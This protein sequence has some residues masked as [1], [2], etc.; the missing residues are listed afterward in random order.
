[1]LDRL[2]GVFPPIPTTFDPATGEVDE[3]AVAANVRRW[4]K[5]GLAGVLALGSNGEAGSLDE[6]EG[7]RLV[8]AAREEVPR[9]R[10]MLVGT[11]KEST[12]ATIRATARAAALGADAVLVRTPSYFKAQMT[13]EALLAHFRA[14]A[15]ASPFPFLLYNRPC[16]TGITLTVP[17]VAALAEHRNIIGM[18]ETSPEL[19][20]L[21]QCVQLNGGRFAVM[22]G[23]A[24]VAYPALV[25]GAAGAI[26]AVANVL[27]DACVSLFE[28]TRAG[29]HDAAIALQR[30]LTPIAQL[31]SSVHGVAGLKCALDVRG[32]HGGPVRGP[33][34]AASAEAREAITRT[35]AQFD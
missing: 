24:P 25:S 18:K 35:L 22:S 28:L 26:L 15:D 17:I 27:P 13:T 21:G 8:A 1:M 19:E 16:V 6:A 29:R 34:L 7:E 33:L 30:R 5:T 20:R 9:D 11:G 14:V 32:F 4:M 2:R 31:V 3:R 12:R 23:W 10:T